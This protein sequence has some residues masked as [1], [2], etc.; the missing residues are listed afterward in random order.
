[1]RQRI[2]IAPWGL[3]GLFMAIYLT[4][5]L[6]AWPITR[7]SGISNGSY[8]FGDFAWLS[9]WSTDCRLDLS[10]PNLFSAYSQIENSPTCPGFNYGMTLIILLSLFPLSWDA[11]IATALIVG[12]IAVFAL[13]FFVGRNYPLNAWEKVLVTVAFFSPGAFLLFERGN[14]DLVIFL[15][16]ILASAFLG[17]GHYTPAYLILVL[18]TLLKFY[19]LPLVLFVALLSRTWKQRVMTATLTIITFVWVLIDLSRGP[20]LPIQGSVQF[21]Y[22]VLNHYFEWL[23]LRLAPLPDLM[24]FLGPLVVWVLLILIQRR[25]GTYQRRRL[26]QGTKALQGDYAFLFSGITFCAMFFVG[27]SYD[28]RL[29]FIAVA[30]IALIVRGAFDRKVRVALWISLITALWGSG[31]LGNSLM[32]IPT[33]IKPFLIGGFQLAGDLAVIL[34]VGIL[35]HF[36]SA[37]VAQKI[38]WYGK[39]Y[40]F[41]TRMENAK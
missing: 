5:F 39:V 9:I 37:A 14:L 33:E 21:G 19:A 36:G 24:G 11:Y 31:A 2:S 7:W 1:M 30:G 15:L 8:L 29:V 25:A 22:P 20:T 17:R 23:G 3:G 16:I 13:G 4:N 27:L 40:A 12:V 41:M 18:A 38:K 26:S 32:S 10:L 28:Y 34:W 35:M 6:L